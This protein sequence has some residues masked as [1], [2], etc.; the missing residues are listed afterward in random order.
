[1]H[2]EGAPSKEA[3]RSC[4]SRHQP[5]T[6]YPLQL[7]SWC[8]ATQSDRSAMFPGY[9]G[10][11]AAAPAAA[12]PAVTTSYT[13]EAAAA[14]AAQVQAMQRLQAQQQQALQA[15]QQQALQAQQ[16]AFAMPSL[17][18]APSAPAA[19][20]AAQQIDPMA[21]YAQAAAASATATNPALSQ[22]AASTGMTPQQ[23]QAVY[24]AS[25]LALRAC[26]DP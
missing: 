24:Q 14:Y 20:P 26:G 11:P 22:L 16:Y 4:V 10:F 17:H 19:Q 6:S 12:M 3:E 8:V 25:A 7:S 18:E 5:C 1:M 21:A 2:V 23:M 9:P 13:P 15:Q